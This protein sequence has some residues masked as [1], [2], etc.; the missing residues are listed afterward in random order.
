ML[1]TRNPKIFK[2]RLMMSTKVGH[3]LKKK[4][5]KRVRFCCFHCFNQVFH[6]SK[7]LYEKPVF[8][9]STALLYFL[10]YLKQCV[11]LRLNVPPSFRPTVEGSQ[12]RTTVQQVKTVREI[13]PFF[14]KAFQLRCIVL[15]LKSF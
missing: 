15:V 1:A 13:I 3:F 7:V 4:L 14:V 10:I 5:K 8:A 2:L 11:F 12:G 6:A 9:V